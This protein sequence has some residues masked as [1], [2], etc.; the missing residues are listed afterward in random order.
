[1]G[2]TKRGTPLAYFV[3]CISDESLFGHDV[4]EII[5]GNCRVS[6]GVG[7]VNHLL[8]LLVRHSFAKLAGDA[9]EVA[10]RD[11]TCAIVVEETEHLV[12]ILAGVT[13]AH[14]RSHHIE[15][16]LEVDV[17]VFVLVK[18]GDHLVDSLV[19]G[20]EAERLH[21]GTELAGVDGT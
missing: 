12:D 8:Q 1:V 10:D 16:L 2:K 9:S 11:G 20:L 17:I 5:R 7:T 3:R 21:S 19:L 14:A 6:V 13:I 15:E 4:V 18:V